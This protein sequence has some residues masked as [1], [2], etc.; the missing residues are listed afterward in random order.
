[1]GLMEPPG[2]SNHVGEHDGDTSEPNGLDRAEASAMRRPGDPQRDCED[3][4][5]NTG[6]KDSAKR[7]LTASACNSV[8][9][10]FGL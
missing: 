6:N 5:N 3:N 1:M 10:D 4:D 7:N 2:R 8:L 9:R